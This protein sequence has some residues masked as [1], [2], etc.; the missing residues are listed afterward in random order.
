ML[1]TFKIN[2]TIM[3]F[4]VVNGLGFCFLKIFMRDTVGLTD[5]AKLELY[6]PEDLRVAEQEEEDL[7]KNR[8]KTL[9]FETTKEFY[10][11]EVDL[12]YEEME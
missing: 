3:I 10:D 6:I 5:R 1:K 7:A 2:G 9:A 8:T 12:D 4:A 11:D